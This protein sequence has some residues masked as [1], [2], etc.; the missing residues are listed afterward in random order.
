MWRRLVLIV[1][2]F[3]GSLAGAILALKSDRV[4]ANLKTHLERVVQQKLGL[5]LSIARLELELMPPAVHLEDVAVFRPGAET[6]LA[7]LHDGSLSL[8]PWPSPSGA[9]VIEHLRLDGLR[10]DLDL[11]ALELLRRRGAA[12][13]GAD[14]GE[15]RSPLGDLEIDVLELMLFNLDVVARRGA[16]ALSLARTDVTMR[17]DRDG[18]RDLSLTIGAA[19]LRD[20]ARHLGFEAHL[21]G[22]L[23][24]SLDRPQ[25]LDLTRAEVYLKEV[26]VRALGVVELEDKPGADLQL[27]SVINLA[28]LREL[29]PAAPA[30]EG[31]ARLGAHVSGPLARPE[32]SYD[33]AVTALRLA[34]QALGDV[35]AAGVVTPQTVEVRSLR[36]TVPKVGE[37]AGH[38]KVT[39]G[40]ALPV[41]LQLRGKNVVLEELLAVTGLPESWVRGRFSGTA[42]GKGQL[43]PLALDLVVE[44]AS[45][46]FAVL[47][48]SYSD[49]EAVAFMTVG[50]T[51][52]AGPIGVSRAAV[53][54]ADLS[55]NRGGS[56][57][58][59]QGSLYLSGRAG[60]EM[61]VS[62]EQVSLPAFGPVAGLVYT[63]TGSFA[64]AV[65]GPYADPTVTA[66]ADVAGFGAGEYLLGDAKATLVYKS[67]LLRIE[68]LAGTRGEGRFSGS[69]HLDW[70][71]AEPQAEASLELTRIEL[72]DLL[73]TLGVAP[74]LA[75][76]F[77]ARV[78]G[79]LDVHGALRSPSGTFEL[80]APASSLD[81]TSF[82][83][84]T[85]EGG[86]GEAE[87]R[88]FG[89]LTTSQGKERLEIAATLFAGGRLTLEAALTDVDL[90]GLAPL[91][92]GV[93]VAGRLSGTAKLDG[94]IEA[95]SGTLR[96]RV[97][98]MVSYQTHLGATTLTG[99]VNGGAMAFE[100]SMLG[101]QMSYEG[102][103]T[104]SRQ[105]PYVVT[106]KFDGAEM[107]QLWPKLAAYDVR[108]RG[109]MFSQGMLTDP[110]TMLADIELSSTRVLYAGLTLDSTRPARLQYAQ[111]VLR[112]VEMPL[113]GSG[114]GLSATGKMGVDGSLQVTVAGSG[115]LEAMRLPFGGLHAVRGRTEGH[116][117][118]SGT[119]D[120]PLFFGKASLQN[121]SA[122]LST[123]SS[124]T[125]LQGGLTLSGRTLDIESLSGKLGGGTVEVGG[126]VSLVADAP[127]EI[128]L[129]ATLDGVE[130]RPTHDLKVNGGGRL[131]LTGPS[132]D[133]LLSGA[134]LIREL[135]YAAN[136][137]LERLIARRAVPPIK[138]GSVDPD[139]AIRLNIAVAAP[140]NLLVTSNVLEAEL[141]ADLVVRGTNERLGLQGSVSTLWARGRYLD[142]VY[143]VER[144]HVFFAEEY[145]IVPEYELR[146]RTRACGIEATV[147]LAGD[148]QQGLSVSAS[149]SDERGQVPQ[150]DVLSCLLV[151]IRRSRLENLATPTQ[152]SVSGAAVYNAQVDR[153]L[154]SRR[155]TDSLSATGIDVLWQVSGLDQEV[156]RLFPLVDE[157]RLASGWS[158]RQKRTTPRI[159]VGKDLGERVQ[160]TYSRALEQEEDQ[161]LSVDYQLNKSMIMQGSW[162][163]VSD[164]QYGDFGLDLR[165]Q[166][167]FQ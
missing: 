21:A 84:L 85:L 80:A 112:I 142:N 150:D 20:G 4:A 121:G 62:G 42:D 72:R 158:A 88:A 135:R 76:R 11:D 53:T 90:V 167:E 140:G 134:L 70:R 108:S 129:R 100:G 55:V 29:W 110:T 113:A 28:R 5:R 146:A 19:Q 74:D 23:D 157:F 143:T 58:R 117:L 148:P 106:A 115:E 31:E 66:T 86:F 109:T 33:L 116:L 44:G 41:S 15:A 10:A 136:I 95:L 18:G 99:D 50:E 126:Q 122:R 96:L 40:A 156:R 149:G 131:E 57:M 97:P 56:A 14:L 123:G 39:L 34:D 38:A 130:L 65:E 133:L 67:K 37:L 47:D 107:A 160:L 22:R 104:L 26:V 139:S 45:H 69:G 25:A 48:R 101:G 91:M 93:D 63:G 119:W 35:V 138:I 120:E 51:T 118:V 125:E 27:E 54:L 98:D 144:G 7:T 151:G 46:E 36:A 103:L 83:S 8:S 61:T 114:L 137:D 52:V 152:P 13:G 24:G 78:D 87:R 71:H 82:G 68:R 127:S 2:V 153:E 161:N 145:R 102:Q 64:A 12:A 124:L 147:D 60:L 3:V 165:L 164:T 9:V 89:M 155:Q 81:R 105:L 92:G 128:N 17:P 111:G 49:P 94:P 32:V 75:R 1:A 16:Q 59:L 132:N 30:L 141:S 73:D 77:E 43:S 166:F 162:N 79:G 154:E 163:S 6:P 159:V